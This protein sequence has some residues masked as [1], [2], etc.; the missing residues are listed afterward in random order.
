[1]ETLY[2]CI[3]TKSEGP[4][5]TSWEEPSITVAY[6]ATKKGSFVWMYVAL[7]KCSHLEETLLVGTWGSQGVW[8]FYLD[9]RRDK[10]N[11][12][13][14]YDCGKVEEPGNVT[15]WRN[16]QPEKSLFPENLMLWTEV[17]QTKAIARTKI[18]PINFG[19]AVCPYVTNQETVYLNE[20][21]YWDVLIILT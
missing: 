10:W 20:I 9:C 14:F 17:L 21:W 1:M 11:I 19:I 5:V 3:A 12:V 6:S 8:I 15:L 18:V 16:G 13:V 4:F 7:T 2:W